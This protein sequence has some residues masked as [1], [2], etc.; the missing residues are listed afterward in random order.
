MAEEKDNED[1]DE[2][3]EKDDDET[4]TTMDVTQVGTKV[5]API[6]ND[7]WITLAAL[8]LERCVPPTVGPGSEV[9]EEDQDEDA[10]E[11]DIFPAGVDED[12]TV[13]DFN[14]EGVEDEGGD[15]SEVE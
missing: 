3:E 4:T 2:K 6:D 5:V 12:E 14:N 1:E 11:M 13:F 10:L 15:E 8:N 9:V 7:K